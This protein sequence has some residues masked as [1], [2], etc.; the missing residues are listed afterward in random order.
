MPD[1]AKLSKL[2]DDNFSA[3][4]RTL[5]DEEWRRPSL[6]TGW[7]NKDVL[8]HLALGLQLPVTRLLLAMARHRGSFDATNEDVT[9]RYAQHRTAQELIDEFDQA[10]TRPQ[11]IGRLLPNPLMLG[12]HVV[13]HLD[14]AL[15][16]GRTADLPPEIAEAVLTVETT[17]PNPFV[18]AVTRAR[19]LAL[20][21]TDA[22]WSRQGSPDLEII[23]AAEH[24]IS[25]LAGRGYAMPHLTGSG[26]SELARR[27]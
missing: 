16:L 8:A 15:P 3:F 19:G 2:Q 22:D 27:I 26:A 17:I 10:R 24:L 9:R 4:A 23:G 1:Y 20:R 14:I 11:G 6:C 13:H 25:V 18:P 7:T 5:T 21:A 12:D